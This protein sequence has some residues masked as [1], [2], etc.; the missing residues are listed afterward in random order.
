MD[1]FGVEVWT[2]GDATVVWPTGGLDLSST[3][4]FQE[5]LASV[6]VAR[7][8]VVVDLSRLT[9]IDSSGLSSLVRGRRAAELMDCQLEVR[10][11]HGWVA[12]VLEHTG[13]AAVLLNGGE[14]ERPR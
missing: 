3:V 7:G 9:F 6:L 4:Q 8:S 5:I 11:A 13:L 2:E 1:G 12:D 14:G 10:G